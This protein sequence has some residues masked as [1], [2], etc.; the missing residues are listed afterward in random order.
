M[1]VISFCSIQ[2]D[3]EIQ[4]CSRC[5]KPVTNRK[6]GIIC[7]AGCYGYFHVECTRVTTQQKLTKMGS[8]KLNWK[9]DTCI[10]I[11][12]RRPA[13]IPKVSKA[14]NGQSLA[15]EPNTTTKQRYLANC[16]FQLP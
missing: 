8:K 2:S 6:G 5:K 15:D 4:N 7:A 3:D 1:T 11:Q 9:C 10:L 12:T 16:C 13:Q 14:P